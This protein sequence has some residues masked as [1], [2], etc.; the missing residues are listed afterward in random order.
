VELEIL[1]PETDLPVRLWDTRTFDRVRQLQFSYNEIEMLDAEGKVVATHPSQF[2]T[3]WIY[4]TEME[5]PLRIAGLA[6][7]QILGGF[8]GRSLLQ[9]TDAMIVQ[10]WTSPVEQ[11]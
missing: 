7:W 11:R 4:K 2:T 5:L 9:E 8:D 10:A 3:R 1:H 6:R